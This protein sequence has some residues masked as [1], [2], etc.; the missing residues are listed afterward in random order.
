VSGLIA[1]DT[2]G[3]VPVVAA[4]EAGSLRYAEVGDQPRA[5]AEEIG[6]MLLA[7]RELLTAAPAAVVV[8]RGPGAYTGLRVGIVAARTLGWAWDVP[9]LGICSL[10]VLAAQSPGFTGTVVT[11]ARRGELYWARY[12]AGSRVEGPG[13]A[14]RDELGG[15]SGPVLGDAELI[16]DPDRRRAGTTVLAP[17]ALASAAVLA[18][19]TDPA[20]A[21]D[22]EPIYLR[23]PD[24]GASRG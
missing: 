12:R 10:D 6:P 8:G 20:D 2:S 7:A 22:T 23:R 18:L 13:V 3:P 24:I 4:R 21:Q 9:V 1:I 17:S 14:G 19:T 11:D 5:H 16:G 15:L